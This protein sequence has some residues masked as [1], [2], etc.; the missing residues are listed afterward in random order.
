MMVAWTLVDFNFPRHAWETDKLE[1][2]TWLLTFVLTVSVSLVWAILIGLAFYFAGQYL[3][4]R[5]SAKDS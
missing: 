3:Q 4:K 5:K 1:F 2:W